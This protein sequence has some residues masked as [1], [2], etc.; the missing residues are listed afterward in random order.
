M[1]KNLKNNKI[2]D[3]FIKI[4]KINYNLNFQLL[5]QIKNLKW[6]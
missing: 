4:I 1:I 3:Y 2:H 6:K 5:L